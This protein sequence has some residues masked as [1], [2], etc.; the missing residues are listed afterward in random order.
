MS[1]GDRRRAASG[2]PVHVF[3]ASAS[4]ALT[5]RCDAVFLP[6]PPVGVRVVPSP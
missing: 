1:V 4:C 6:L 5:E 2:Y 3:D